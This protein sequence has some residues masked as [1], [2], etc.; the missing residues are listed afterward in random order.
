[1]YIIILI[2]YIYTL[3]I[4]HDIIITSSRFHLIGLLTLFIQDVGDV[5]L[6]LS[7]TLIYFKIQDGKEHWIPETCANISFTIFTIQQ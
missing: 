2:I 6:E 4:A 7:K 5:F 1:M 3:H